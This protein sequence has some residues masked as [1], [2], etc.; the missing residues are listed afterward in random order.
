MQ[1]AGSNQSEFC[2][3][4]TALSYPTNT[5]K[6]RA[7]KNGCPTYPAYDIVFE[8][9]EVNDDFSNVDVSIVIGGQ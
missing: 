1:S 3:S 5:R 9:D 6:C 4:G 7:T 8:M 2:R